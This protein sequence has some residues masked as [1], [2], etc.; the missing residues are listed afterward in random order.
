MSNIVYIATSLDGFIADKNN[1]ID[2]LHDIPNPEGS[3]LGFSAFMDRIDAIVMGRNTVEMVLR[4]GCD[5]P[6]SKPV[7]MLSN[8]LK[9]V[10][11]GYEDKIFL[12][13]GDLND[14]VSALNE[15]GYADLYVD[16][17]LTV[18]SFLKHD[19]IDELIITTIPVLLGG[20]IPLFGD[21][22]EPLKFK[23]I[24]AEPLLNCLVKNTFVRDR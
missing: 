23:H 19:L 15:Q 16:G 24:N 18:Q 2:W 14:V 22:A 6:Y 9:S 12:V 8:T 10:P 11:T 17:G 5:W 1:R 3:D 13:N 7:F 21:L 4:F 20:G